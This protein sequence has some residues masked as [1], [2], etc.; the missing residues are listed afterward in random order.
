MRSQVRY[1][2]Y[3]AGVKLL[4]ER[5]PE[6]AG[7]P[8]DVP[9][10]RDLD[11]T[12]DAPATFFVG[13]NGTGKS[14]LMEAIAVLGRLPVSGGGRNELG[15]THG[16]ESD[17]EFSR[18]LRPTFRRHPKD[19]FFL[20]AEFEAHFASL[21]DQRGSDPDFLGDPYSRFGGR[22]LHER[23]H[24]E[25]FLAILQ[26]RIKA[27]MF[28]F[29]EPESALSPQRQLALLALM[30][31]LAAT[32]QA[33]FFVATHSPILLTYPGATILNFDHDGIRRTAMEDTSH[34]QITRGIL[35]NP[36]LYWKHLIE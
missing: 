17:C 13:E 29:D 32:G 6:N 10:L 19:G 33:Q 21:L 31:D 35:E 22:S 26:N 8:F 24:G 34:Y 7:Y 12:F 20:R 3:L 36:Q 30:H 14:T 28:L 18:A 2:P 4:A 1:K 16:P 11:L 5:V 25:A 27:G 23:S 15:S 9:A